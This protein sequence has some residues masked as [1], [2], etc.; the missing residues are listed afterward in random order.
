MGS[1]LETAI[2]GAT[3]S[4]AVLCEI[5]RELPFL[6][7]PTGQQT[8]EI[9]AAAG[10]DLPHHPL[11][12]IPGKGA[13]RFPDFCGK[14]LF[15]RKPGIEIPLGHL[16]NRNLKGITGFL[17]SKDNILKCRQTSELT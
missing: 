11:P 1:F 16:I 2:S 7:V 10:L 14:S 3:S 5:V 4:C 12:V 17:F 6:W 15:L 8:T 13:I 9:K